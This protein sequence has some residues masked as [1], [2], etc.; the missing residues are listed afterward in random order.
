VPDIE[1]STQIEGIVLVHLQPHPDD[2][3]RFLETYRHEW[4]PGTPPMVQSSRSDSYKGVIRALHYHLKQADY[5]HVP[6]GRLLVALHDLRRSSPTQ[7]ATQTVEVGEGAD[8]CVYIPP[9]VAH[10][11]QAL[12]DATLTYLVD[13]YYDASDE[14]GLAW[15]DPELGIDWPVPDPILSERDR[16]NPKGAEIPED[17]RPA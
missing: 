17:L 13:R 2:R 6:A 3:G 15:D 4:L 14:H 8:I 7:G 12:T 16:A 11:F 10:G 9:G 5:W 1:H